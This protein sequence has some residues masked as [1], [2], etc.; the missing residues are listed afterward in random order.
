MRAALAHSFSFYVPAS[1]CGFFWLCRAGS[2]GLRDW[3]ELL[4]RAPQ[5]IPSS[6]TI[7]RERRL[8]SQHFEKSFHRSVTCLS[9]NPS[10]YPATS[11][12]IMVCGTAFPVYFVTIPVAF[13]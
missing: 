6:I 11:V 12:R 5:I 13:G 10:L 1:V 9:R 3:G 8:G 4:A 7:C 2:Q